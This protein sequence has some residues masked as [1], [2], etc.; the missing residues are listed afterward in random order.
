MAS[1]SSPECLRTRFRVNGS[2]S[3]SVWPGRAGDEFGPGMPPSWHWRRKRRLLPPMSKSSSRRGSN[4]TSFALRVGGQTHRLRNPLRRCPRQCRLSVAQRGESFRRCR[5]ARHPSTTLARLG[6][7]LAKRRRLLRRPNR[8][9]AQ[10]P[11][12][13]P[14]G[15][16]MKPSLT[17][18]SPTTS[19]T[20]NIFEKNSG[21]TASVQRAGLV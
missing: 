5:T 10:G 1:S 21:W 20:Q 16:Y 17:M 13:H 19:A 8:T 7:G 4:R 18:G 15:G 3:V 2:T 12:G 11:A 6:S 9:A 14:K